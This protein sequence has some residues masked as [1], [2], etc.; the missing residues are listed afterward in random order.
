MYSL[1][2]WGE[3]EFCSSFQFQMPSECIFYRPC[4]QNFTAVPNRF[5]YRQIAPCTVFILIFS[6]VHYCFRCRQ[7]ALSVALVVNISLQ[8][9]IVSYAVRV[10]HLA[11]LCFF[12]GVQN[13]FKQSQNACFRDSGVTKRD[14]K[15]RQ[16][17][18][19][20]SPCIQKYQVGPTH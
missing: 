20:Y 9:Y 19:F 5:K 8:F 13:R 1:L 16:K 12:K 17:L 15:Q 10:H 11:S 2:T 3:G 7:N 6:V 14:F 4:F 18:P